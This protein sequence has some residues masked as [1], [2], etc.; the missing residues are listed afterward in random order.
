M[1]LVGM[2]AGNRAGQGVPRFVDERLGPTRD[3]RSDLIGLAAD[4]ACT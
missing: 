1:R 4:V 2:P 3:R